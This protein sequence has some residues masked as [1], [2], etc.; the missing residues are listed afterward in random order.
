MRE[1]THQ[2]DTCAFCHQPIT[3]QQWPYKRLASGEKAHLACWLDAE[4]KAKK[5]PD[6]G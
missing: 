4:E 1:E 5:K 6:A 2:Q 3:Q